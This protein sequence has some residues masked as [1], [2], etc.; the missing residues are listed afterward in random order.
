MAGHAEPLAILKHPGIG[1]A[2]E[3]LIGLAAVGAL[4]MIIADHDAVAP[5]ISTFTSS[6]LM[7]LG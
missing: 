5:Y 7:M 6:I 3:M 2:P 1:E 4:R